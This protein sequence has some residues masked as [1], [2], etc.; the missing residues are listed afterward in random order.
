VADVSRIFQ[1]PPFKLADPSR[2][3]FA[4]A[5]EGSRHFAMMCLAPW[6][7][8]VQR[9]FSM[10]VPSRQYRL[11]IDLGD[12]LRADPEARWASWQRARAAGVLSPNDVRIEEGWPA[13]SDE[14]ADSIQPPVA[15]GRPASVDAGDGSPVAEPAP[16]PTDG[17]D[18]Q[19]E[20]DQAASG[21]IA[22]LNARRAGHGD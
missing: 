3:T 16:P 14:T 5:C 20:A 6:V 18:N 1:V 19:A 7:A 22:R 10:S 11:V 13:S 9:A 21:K 17:D 2:S 4:S 8:K 12:L 15:G